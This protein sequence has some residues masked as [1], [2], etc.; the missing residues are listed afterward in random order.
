MRKY[1]FDL[2]QKILLE[3]G[4]PFALVS[5]NQEERKQLSI[6]FIHEKLI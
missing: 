1:F 6:D 4:V 2:Y 5:G 3:S